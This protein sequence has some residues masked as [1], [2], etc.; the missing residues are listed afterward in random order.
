MDPKTTPKATPEWLPNR[1]Q[2]GSQ[3][4]PKMGSKLGH[5][6]V[7]KVAIPFERE[8]LFPKSDRPPAEDESGPTPPL[9]L[10]PLIY[11]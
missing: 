6:R 5:F 8:A 11:K 4:D 9:T 2:D 3:T 7:P 10:P 1:P